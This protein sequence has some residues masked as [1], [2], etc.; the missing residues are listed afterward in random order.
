MRTVFT[1]SQ[2][3]ELEHV[4][5]ETQYPDIC[6]REE[7]AHRIHLTEARVQ[8]CYF[9]QSCCPLVAEM[10]EEYTDITVH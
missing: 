6:T 8:V 9:T 3:L 4:F 5:A 2:L 7:L 10:V 1:H